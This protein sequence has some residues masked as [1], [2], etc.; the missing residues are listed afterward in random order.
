MKLIHRSKILSGMRIKQNLYRHDG[1]LATPKGIMINKRE[2]DIIENYEHEFVLVD[3]RTNNLHNSEN[4]LNESLNIIEHVMTNSYLWSYSFGEKFY[5]LF[6][7][8]LFKNKRRGEAVASL[9][10][11]NSYE[12]SHAI[13]VSIITLSILSE[14]DE[15]NINLKMA[16]IFFLT[17]MREVGRTEEIRAMQKSGNLTREQY[18]Q[19][20]DIP[21]K[22]VEAV[23]KMGFNPYEVKFLYELNERYDG[24]G[25]RRMSGTDIEHLAQLINI[26]SVYDEMSSYKTDKERDTQQEVYRV[27]LAEKGKAFNPSILALFFSRFKPYEVGEMVELTNGATAQVIVLRSE[28]KFLPI[29]EY[30]EEG[31]QNKKVIDLS[32]EKIEIKK[33]EEYI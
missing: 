9:L 4:D 21:E 22:T 17:L 5:N 14:N 1:L 19:I 28:A 16:E 25:P 13:N 29:V 32:K 20:K 33:I 31:T 7:E 23:T 3:T 26:A 18:N 24:T 12:I 2:K 8:V 11:L 10:S 30:V 6:T 15:A 27:L